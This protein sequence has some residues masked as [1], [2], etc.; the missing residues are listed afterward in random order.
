MTPIVNGLENDFAGRAEV[1]HLDANEAGNASL[2]QQFG[3]R[4]HP[5]FV[6]LDENGQA[7]QTFI[8]PQTGTVLSEALAAVTA[9]AN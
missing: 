5:T 2:Q 7:V 9:S 1:L 6:V 3:L 4:G 8:G